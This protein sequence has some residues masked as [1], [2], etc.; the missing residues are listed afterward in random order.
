MSGNHESREKL[1]CRKTSTHMEAINGQ[2]QAKDK[3]RKKFVKI[4]TKRSDERYQRS[5]VNRTV[6]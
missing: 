4:R 6:T 5:I 2:H 1:G 3:Q